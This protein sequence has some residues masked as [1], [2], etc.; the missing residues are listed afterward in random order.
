MAEQDR[1]LDE[2]VEL[3]DVVGP[4]DLGQGGFGLWA[5]GIEHQ[6]IH[7]AEE[8]ADRGDEVGDLAL[9]GDIGRDGFG[10]AAFGADGLDDGR[11]VLAVPQAVDDHGRPVGGESPRDRA[12]QAA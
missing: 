5:G 10:H 1:A 6:H 9:I 7:G 3:G 11:R 8:R 4:G 2:E 12:T